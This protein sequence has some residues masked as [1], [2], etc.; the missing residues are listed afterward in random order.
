MSAYY[1]PP[2]PAILLKQREPLLVPA[3]VP[4]GYIEEIFIYN[5]CN[6]LSLS[7]GVSTN[8]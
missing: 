4:S 1:P 7:V 6:Y 2:P 5:T 8:R 3:A